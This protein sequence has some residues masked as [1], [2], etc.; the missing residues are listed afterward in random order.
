MTETQMLEELDF[1][2]QQKELL[3][4]EHM[5]LFAPG[6][7]PVEQQAQIKVNPQKSK[8]HLRYPYNSEAS[9]HESQTQ[10]KPLMSGLEVHQH[11]AVPSQAQLTPQSPEPNV[12]TA[13]GLSTDQ[14]ATP[15]I[16]S[17]LLNPPILPN[18]DLPMTDAE[19]S[20]AIKT[21]IARTNLAYH[22]GGHESPD[23]ESPELLLAAMGL[24]TNGT[25]RGLQKTAS[26]DVL[27]AVPEE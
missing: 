16:G 26:V 25:L 22:T 18:A 17:Q 8:L 2:R 14:N 27:P 20:Y 5:E 1:V 12:T 7:S 6:N 24:G 11:I 21:T 15:G 10:L 13:M 9:L 4:K 23:R 19:K 3:L